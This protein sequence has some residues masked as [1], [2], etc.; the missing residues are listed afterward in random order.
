M[1]AARA[2][3]AW[4]ALRGGLDQSYQHRRRR[5]TRAPSSRSS[6]ERILAIRHRGP[7]ETRCSSF[8][9]EAQRV[10]PTS[11]TR[12]PVRRDA[13]RAAAYIN[14]SYDRHYLGRPAGRRGQQSIRG[15]PDTLPALVAFIGA[16][17][18]PRTATVRLRYAFC[19]VF[20]EISAKKVVRL[21]VKA[22]WLSR[23]LTCPAPG[24]TT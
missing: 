20:T 7:D 16:R 1:A 6:E 17:V 21:A 9:P 8:T 18:M 15:R 19:V 3:Q 4:C 12:S 11:T 14:L 24:I 2:R 23:L 22:W 13:V 5:P 10:G